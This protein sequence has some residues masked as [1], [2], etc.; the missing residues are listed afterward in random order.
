VATSS[1]DILFILES[2]AGPVPRVSAALP[3]GAAFLTL[4]EKP[5]GR[6]PRDR[7]HWRNAFFR[8]LGATEK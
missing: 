8:R 2:W 7:P 6:E 5:T 1:P 4:A 3:E